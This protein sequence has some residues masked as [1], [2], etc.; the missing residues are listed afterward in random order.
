MIKLKYVYIARDETDK[1]LTSVCTGCEPLKG[2]RNR[3]IAPAFHRYALSIF[4][5][6]P[7]AVKVEVMDLSGWTPGADIEALPWIVT[8]ART[9]ET[10]ALSPRALSFSF[11]GSDVETI[12]SP[13]QA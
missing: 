6:H 7:T 13:F 8:A 5:M 12:A 9:E 1:K 2:V 11:P 4:A 3:C 10:R